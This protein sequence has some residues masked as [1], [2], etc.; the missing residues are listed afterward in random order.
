MGATTSTTI[1]TFNTISGV[2]TV[3]G[4]GWNHT[5]EGFDSALSCWMQ[6]SGQDG[7]C[8]AEGE[9]MHIQGSVWRARVAR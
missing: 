5:Y 6:A 9:Q 1:F 8:L 7:F 3:R 4:G 2:G